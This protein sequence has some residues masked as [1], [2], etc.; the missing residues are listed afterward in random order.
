MVFGLLA[1]YG[2]GRWGLH[3]IGVA[4]RLCRLYRKVRCVLG[5][6]SICEFTHVFPPHLENRRRRV[7]A[8]SKTRVNPHG[9]L[10]EFRGEWCACSS[11]GRTRSEEHTSELQS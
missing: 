7:L 10:S 2:R 1:N 4:S 11:A 5:L 6:N 3:Q 8:S 9:S